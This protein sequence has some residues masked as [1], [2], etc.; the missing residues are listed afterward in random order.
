[1]ELTEPSVKIPVDRNSDFRETACVVPAEE[2]LLD[3]C[4]VVLVLEDVEGTPMVTPAA[5]AEVVHADWSE[6]ISASLIVPP[7]FV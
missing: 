4:V 1:M 2:L 3:V 5:V 7:I 6:V